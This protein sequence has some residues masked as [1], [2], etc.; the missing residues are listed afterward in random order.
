MQSQH[1]VFDRSDITNSVPHPFAS[2]LAKGWETTEA[3]RTNSFGYPISAGR[4]YTVT[5]RSK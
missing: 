5:R 4:E 1:Q 3:K 2:F